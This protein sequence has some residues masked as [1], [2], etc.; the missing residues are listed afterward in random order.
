[1]VAQPP[2]IE[3]RNLVKRYGSLVA[4]DGVDLT[5][6]QGECFGFL[7]PNGAGKS[8]VIRM[9]SCVSP[10]T[11]GEL[12]VLS[13]DVKR[14]ARR[15]KYLLGVVPQE[16]NLDSN[17]TVRGNLASY[18]RCFDV[19]SDTARQRIEEALKLFQLEERM[20]SPIETLSGG[21]KRRLLIARALLNRPSLLVLDEPTV[22]LDPQARHMVWKKVRQLKESGI[23]MVL[24]THYMDEAYYLCDR[25]VI[26]DMGRIVVEGRPPD[27]V[28]RYAGREV[29]EVHGDGAGS[30]EAVA[31]LR[32]R[33]LEV[34]D[35][36]D[37][38]H[39]FAPDGRSLPDE[40]GLDNLPFER[41][42][43]NLEDVFLRL[44]GRGLREE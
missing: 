7:G 14:D 17:L 34:E 26:M 16:E 2:V 31:R 40:L 1:M 27:L 42:N 37:L 13:M 29:L 19:P 43:A 35:S 41:R 44:T 18:A 21:M 22:G 33:G 36:G 25:L 38:I 39:A 9:M 12:R 32:Q 15:I 11:A 30:G 8:T 23:T 24:T 5:V 6:R 10:V 28:H 4:V 20:D 3:A